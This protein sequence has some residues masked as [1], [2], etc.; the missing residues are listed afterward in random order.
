VAAIAVS[1][2]NKVKEL[3]AGTGQNFFAQFHAAVQNDPTFKGVTWA[4]TANGAACSPGCGTLSM[5]DPY[6]AFYTPPANVPAGPADT[7]S[8][9][10]TSLTDSTKSDTDAFTI[11]DGTTACGTGGNESVLNGQYAIMLQGWSGSGT[12]TPILFGASFGAD[13]TGKITGGQDQFNPFFNHSYSGASLIPSASSYSV[14]PDN[15]GCL[16]LTDQ[17][18]ATFALR[19]SV[20]GITNRIASKGDVIFFN[21]QS[22]TPER[23]SGIL[24]RQAPTA[25]S[26]SALASNFA[27]GVDGWGG[28]SGA[29]THFALA[30][31]FAQSGG[32]LSSP[33]FDANS[34]GELQSQNQVG[35]MNFGTIP[36]IATTTGMAYATL[37]LPGPSVGSADVTVY[38]IS[39]S[40]LF[41]ICNDLGNTG[42][43]AVFSGRA[44]AT[45]SSFSSS[46]VLPNY[47][48]RFSGGSS[49]GAAAAIGLAGFSGGISGTVAGS[50]Y[51]YWGGTA[52]YQKLTGTYG[53]TEASGRLAIS[54]TGSETSPICY[55][56]GPLDGVSGFCISTDS[57]ASL[58]VL[59]AQPAATYGNSSLSGN[60]FFGSMEPGDNT[61]PDLSGVVSISSGSLTGTEDESAPAGLSLASPFSAM[62]SI[63]A[64]GSG[65]LGADTVAV[66]NGTVLYFID[67]ANGAAAQV[68]VFE[69]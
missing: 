49:G 7:P 63:N 34:G 2:Q 31:S 19:F 24:R 25:F 54:G 59:D 43:G 57:T 51:Q 22:A 35:L 69:E 48:F 68:Q 40:E 36:P 45:P 10:A 26:L 20:G 53:F 14:G 47:V 1:I 15:R 56:T 55:L 65:S 16:I 38:V 4:L 17:F 32:T 52:S 50:I 41:F 8:I 67:E 6:N 46:S 3:A 29:F 44:I 37:L 60:F 18:E 23:A 61:V 66:T 9:T 64:S 21:Q 27:L 30:G 13:G 58:G 11:F 5:V 28:S 62:L 42:I 33:V 39:S 12:G